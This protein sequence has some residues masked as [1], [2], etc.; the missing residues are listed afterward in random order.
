M[1][2]GIYCGGQNPV[3]CGSYTFENEIFRALINSDVEGDLTFVLYGHEKEP[4]TVLPA[5]PHIEWA[6]LYC[7][8]KNNFLSKVSRLNRKLMNGLSFS[9]NKA[10]VLSGHEENIKQ[11]RERHKIDVL[12]FFGPY[13]LELDVPYIATVWDLQHRLQPY[14]PEVSFG[15]EWNEREKYYETFLRKASFILTGTQVGKTEVEKFYQIS[16]ERIRV[17][18]F[19]TPQMKAEKADFHAKNILEKYK[20]PNKYLLYP[21]RFFPHKNHANLL[22]AT[23]LLNEK[24]GYEFPVV[25]VG[26]DA[27]NQ[28]YIKKLTAEL[29]LNKQVHFLGF[30]PKEDLQ[31]LYKAAFAL[32][33]VTFF[34]PD[35]L[36]P[37]EAFSLGCPVIASKV[38][39]AEEQLG[40]S[41]LLVD[42]KDPE[43][44][45]SAIKNLWEDEALRQNLVQSGYDRAARYTGKHYVKEVFTILREFQAI[46]RC[47]Q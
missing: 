33:F 3:L 4:P 40:D 2:I 12:W 43:H 36:P 38:S 14:F 17:I 23:K 45:A 39:G 9:K 29:G 47:W 15:T 25:F 11:F 41:A 20:I 28:G 1:R 27:G 24:Y 6:S 10:K 30:V 7:S 22:L 32:T 5:V 31:A 21:A 34:G 18:P 37:L 26:P 42:P 44:I 19:P 8:P 16:S 46:R 13:G 35:N